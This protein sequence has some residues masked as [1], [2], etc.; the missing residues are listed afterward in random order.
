MV[1]STLERKGTVVG[2]FNDRLQA[3]WDE[4]RFV[5]V[6]LDPDMDKIFERAP[7]R[8]TDFR[9]TASV[10]VP[11]LQEVI[12]ATHDVVCAYKP[13]WAF[14]LRHGAYGL[15]MLEQI[16]TYIRRHY[17]DVVVI[18]D[19]KVADIGNTNLGYAQYAF[20][21]L[22]V[23]AVTVHPYMGYMAMSPFLDRDDRGVIVLARTSNEGADEFQD[24]EIDWAVM[25]REEPPPGIDSMYEYVAHQ[26]AITW[27]HGGNCAVVVG[28]TVPEE[29]RVVR[30]LV[31]DGIPILIPGVGAQGGS[32][33]LAVQNGKNSRGDG[34]IV[35]A[36]RSVL[37]ADAVD[38]QSFTEAARNEVLRM[39]AVIRSTLNPAAFMPPP[40]N[41]V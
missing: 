39:N 32:L 18:L 22:D 8:M 30:G 38:G 31:G 29:L 2:R 1:G 15:E 34:F 17:P 4:G 9:G 5:C 33:E 24:L 12:N 13:N 26:V 20:D 3:Q 21:I 19:A 41:D 23:D 6:G 40:G 25:P 7:S 28:A 27:N 37:Y 10:L 11:Y 16:V 14:F 35:N 36:S